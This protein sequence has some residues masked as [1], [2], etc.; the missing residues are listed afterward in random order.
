MNR[1]AGLY[2][3]MKANNWT[4]QTFLMGRGNLRIAARMFPKICLK[5]LFQNH[6]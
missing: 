1:R 6:Q 5:W 2:H 4:K 3:P